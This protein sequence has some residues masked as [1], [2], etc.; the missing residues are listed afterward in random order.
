M[1]WGQMFNVQSK[2]KPLCKKLDHDE[3][4]V[5]FRNEDGYF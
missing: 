1:P 5:V 3:S 2:Y 4:T